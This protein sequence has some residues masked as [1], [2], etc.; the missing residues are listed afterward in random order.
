MAEAGL[1]AG[2]YYAPSLTIAPHTSVPEYKTGD[3]NPRPTGSLWIKTTQP[4][5][6]ANWKV[7]VWNDA[8]KLWDTSSAPIY[9]TPEAA[10]AGLDKTLGGSGLSLSLSLIHI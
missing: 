1:T 4:N 2:T 9:A 10:L 8:T 3:T 7:K 5:K 6:G